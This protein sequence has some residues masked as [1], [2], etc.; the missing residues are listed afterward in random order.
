MMMFALIA[1]VKTITLLL[2]CLASISLPLPSVAQ[3]DVPQPS[4]TPQPVKVGILAVPPFAFKNKQGAWD[5][6]AMTL[7]KKTSESADLAYEFVELTTL[8]H[9]LDGVRSGELLTVISGLNITAEREKLGSFST[10]FYVTDMAVAMNASDKSVYARIMGHLA[11]P[12]SIVYIMVLLGLIL[13]YALVFLWVESDR[14]PEICEPGAPRSRNFIHSMIWS[15]MLATGLEADLHKNKTLLLRFLAM[16][17]YFVGLFSVSAFVAILSSSLTVNELGQMSFHDLNLNEKRVGVIRDSRSAEYCAHEFMACETFDTL[18][19]GMVMLK[20]GKLDVVVGQKVELYT[21]AS[22][23]KL[24]LDYVNIPNM[25]SYYAFY[26]QDGFE[27]M[28]DFNEALME[29]VDHPSY[30]ALLGRY[31]RSN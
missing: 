30:P 15:I 12:K 1:R 2:F 5:G 26:F 11:S 4:V 27:G 18:A 24:T 10:P 28:K 31:V 7:W 20:E 25:R 9:A 19:E 8:D 29:V 21:E 3:T 13:A 17:L 22:K 14:N 6:L 16:A 23:I